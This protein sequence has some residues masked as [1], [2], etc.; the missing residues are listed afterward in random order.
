MRLGTA[1]AQSCLGMLC[2]GKVAEC[3]ATAECSSVR[4]GNGNVL[5]REVLR[6]HCIGM[7]GEAEMRQG[8]V[9]HST[10]KA[11]HSVA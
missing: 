11:W 6:R 4:F 8:Y 5:L 9:R 1:E 2:K 10:A 3:M 7:R